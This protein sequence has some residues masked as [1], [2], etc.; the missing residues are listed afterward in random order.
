MKD[1]KTL[2]KI[3]QVLREIGLLY[4]RPERL[5]WVPGKALGGLYVSW[6][7]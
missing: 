2:L 1:T 5:I 6:V 4:L 3:M 7:A